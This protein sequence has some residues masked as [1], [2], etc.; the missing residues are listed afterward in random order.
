MLDL[1]IKAL[2]KVQR[3]SSRVHS[4]IQQFCLDFSKEEHLVKNIALTTLV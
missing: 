2:Y 1:T 3:Q 4:T